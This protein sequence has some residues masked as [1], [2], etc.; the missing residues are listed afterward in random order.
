MNVHLAVMLALPQTEPNGGEATLFRTGRM[1]AVSPQ[2]SALTKATV[3]RILAA[4]APRPKAAV[5]RKSEQNRVRFCSLLVE[6]SGLE[7][8]TPCL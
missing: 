6:T 8:L 5:S 2:V 7:P 4:G 3:R 1:Q